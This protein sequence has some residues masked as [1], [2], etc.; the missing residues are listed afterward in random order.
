MLREQTC[1]IITSPV[2]VKCTKIPAS[3][4]AWCQLRCSDR[5]PVAWAI[6]FLAIILLGTKQSYSYFSGFSYYFVSV[7]S[8]TIKNKV[9][10]FTE[11]EER[12]KCSFGSR[13]MSDGVGKIMAIP[14]LQMRTLKL[15][16]SV[17]QKVV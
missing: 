2:K 13:E 14:I 15:S 3:E 9:C 6:E 16:N 12:I 4:K 1:C 11:R 5:L 17:F 7:S 10:L 8:F